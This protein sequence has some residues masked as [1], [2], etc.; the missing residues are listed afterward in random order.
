LWSANE[1]KKKKIYFLRFRV[2][3]RLGCVKN[4]SRTLPTIWYSSNRNKVEIK[5]IFVRF[6]SQYVHTSKQAGLSRCKI[7]SLIVPL[8]L[9]YP[10]WI[11]P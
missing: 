10:L 11:F 2:V 5:F 8:V 1:K 7:Q 3:W 4:T 9:M 6:A